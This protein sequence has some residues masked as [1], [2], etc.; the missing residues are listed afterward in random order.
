[1]AKNRIAKTY[2][3]DDE[4][5][6]QLWYKCLDSKCPCDE[7][8]HEISLT[9]IKNSN[10]IE[11][12]MF[13]KF[14]YEEYYSRYNWFE[15]KWIRLKDGLKIIFG[16]FINLT[17]EFTFE[18]EEQI[19]DYLEAIEGGLKIIREKKENANRKEKEKN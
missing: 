12:E 10:I 8:S 4:Y 14:Y 5:E 13:K 18:G 2:E 7:C 16:G 15:R 3:F 6:Q 1:M 9:Y 17:S 19:N 11:F